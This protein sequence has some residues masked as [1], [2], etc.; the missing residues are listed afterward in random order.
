MP[1][2]GPE[3]GSNKVNIRAVTR[4]APLQ[5]ISAAT[6]VVATSVSIFT[7]QP[8]QAGLVDCRL[9]G[10]HKFVFNEG[11]PAFKETFVCDNIATTKPNK[12]NPNPPRPAVGVE[13]IISA[14]GSFNGRPGDNDS[15]TINHFVQTSAPNIGY[16]IISGNQQMKI[17]FQVDPRLD[18]PE[19]PPLDSG[20][21]TFS[22]QINSKLDG[23]AFW[24][25]PADFLKTF[26]YKVNDVSLPLRAQGIGD[27]VL[28]GS[29]GTGTFTITNPGAD[30]KITAINVTQGKTQ[31]DKT[32][33]PTRGALSG[34]CTVG[35][36]LPF[37]GTC[38]V[39]FAFTT[40]ALDIGHDQG[41]TPF[42]LDF[43]LDDGRTA[44]ARS[45]I[46][47]KRQTDC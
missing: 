24:S 30:G 44:K 1:D 31:G 15:P 14:P 11:D 3:I 12:K 20:L 23:T 13:A 32:D 35:Q 39:A 8:A 38:T 10:P 25:N 41:A 2:L 42:S 27:N 43:S 28:E 21:T 4:H 18:G 6:A 19:P 7:P 33:I 40:G 29:G 36:I 16:S 9:V 26:S 47:C 5:F 46:V 45:E 37:G 22:I 17:T 34:S